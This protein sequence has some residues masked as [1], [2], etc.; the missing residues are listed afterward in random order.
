[1][2]EVV[3]SNRLKKD[4]K[5]AAKR[6]RDIA[7][8]EKIV[9]RLATR[10]PLPEKNRDHVLAGEYSGFRECY[11]APDWLL[12]YRIEDEDLILYLMRTGI[13]AICFERKSMAGD[14]AMLFS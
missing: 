11:I 7:L 6:N 3:L 14:P 4:L 9:D 10:K 12:I 8:L 5:P 13:Q 2:L 1:M